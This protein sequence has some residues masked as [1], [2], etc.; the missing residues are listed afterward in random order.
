[1]IAG[2]VLRDLIDAAESRESQMKARLVTVIGES[3][4]LLPHMLQYYKSVGVEEII[5]HAHLNSYDQSRIEHISEAASH[6]DVKVSSFNIGPWFPTTNLHLYELSRADHPQDWFLL[7]D[8]DEFQ[9]FPDELL[10]VLGFCNR[11][12]YDFIE[13]CLIDRVSTSGELG[14]ATTDQPIWSQFP[15]GSVFA[16]RCLGSVANKIVAA[17]GFVKIGIGQ[18]HAYTGIACPSSEVYIPVHHFKWVEGLFSRLDQ[19]VQFLNLIQKAP[20]SNAGLY[21]SECRRFMAYFERKG[22]IEI[23]DPQLLAAA[24]GSIYPFE[25]PFWRLLRE[26]RSAADYFSVELA[27]RR[28]WVDCSVHQVAQTTR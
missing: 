19:R 17:K 26:W 1:M 28:N 8:Q 9:V 3:L 16:A 20:F 10:D 22:R 25:Y 11:K 18:H 2:D 27:R 23:E 5:I 15:I 21:L 13:G 6:F 7:A 14:R 12:G 24:C 4:D